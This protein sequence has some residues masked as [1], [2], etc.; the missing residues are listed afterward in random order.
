MGTEHGD[1]L[2]GVG[3]VQRH[4]KEGGTPLD[5]SLCVV[6]GLFQGNVSQNGKQRVF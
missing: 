4:L 3:A 6:H 2:Q 1:L 5:G